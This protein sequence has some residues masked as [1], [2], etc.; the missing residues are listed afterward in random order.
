MSGYL[1]DTSALSAYLNK[2]HPHHAMAMSVVASLPVQSAKLVSAVT[3]AE[4]D[5]GIRFA[6]VQGSRRLDEYRARLDV[7]RQYASLDQWHSLLCFIH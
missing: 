2:D 7:V 3:L 6:E 1:L 5:Y 4:L